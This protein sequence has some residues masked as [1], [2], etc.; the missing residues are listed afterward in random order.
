MNLIEE[1]KEEEGFRG[2]VYKDTLGFDTIGYGTKLPLNEKE[3][4]LLLVSRMDDAKKE[5]LRR[6]NDLDIEDEAWDILY[7]MSYQL[8]VS[9]VL[10]FKN[11]IKALRRRDYNE[12]ANQMLDSLW[13]KQ[14]PARANRMA[15]MMRKL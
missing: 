2:I 6:L 8:G 9:G 7:A 13:A 1:T 14:T 10:N 15:D 3:A 11:M 4:T 12:A 5:L